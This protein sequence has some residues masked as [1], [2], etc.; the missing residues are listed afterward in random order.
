MVHKVDSIIGFR[1]ALVTLV[2]LLIGVAGGVG[3]FVTFVY[4]YTLLIQE[5]RNSRGAQLL[6]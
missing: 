2:F 3:V 5:Y 6:F 1:L 4:K